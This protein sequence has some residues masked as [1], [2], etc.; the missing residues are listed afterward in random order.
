MRILTVSRLLA[1]SFALIGALATG[2]DAGRVSR[3][4]AI[5]I[6]F[7]NQAADMSGIW[8]D[9]I[10]SE[11]V[12]AMNVAANDVST[13]WRNG[14]QVIIGSDLKAGTRLIVVDHPIYFGSTRVGGYHYTDRAGAF[15]IFDL[16]IAASQEGADGPFLFGSHE[17]EEMLADPSARRFIAGH[18]AE[19]A[20]P[21]VCCHYDVTLS[22]GN[23]VPLSDFVLP[24]WFNRRAGGPFDFVNSSFVTSPFEYG[25]GGF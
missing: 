24:S 23:V 11:F 17:L 14:R 19:I 7:I 9:S 8:D 15:A 12:E 6:K 20:D 16:T 3:V 5:P 22:D 18:F 13:Y 1:A 21:V 2:A 10:R 4:P 25:P